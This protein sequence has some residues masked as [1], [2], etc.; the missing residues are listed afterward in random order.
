MYSRTESY[1]CILLFPTKYI[2]KGWRYTA[3]RKQFLT[4]IKNLGRPLGNIPNEEVLET[5]EL[6]V[7]TFA[8]CY[9]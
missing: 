1:G 9:L 3:Y 2:Q 8:H 6:V 7:M 4:D 5:I